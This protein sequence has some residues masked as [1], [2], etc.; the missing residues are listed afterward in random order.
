[1]G[2]HPRVLEG[3]TISWPRGGGEQ[4]WTTR[5]VRAG[6]R[7]EVEGCPVLGDP[8]PRG[9]GGLGRLEADSG[10]QGRRALRNVRIWIRRVHMD[11]APSNGDVPGQ[12]PGSLAAL[13]R[14]SLWGGDSEEGSRHSGTHTDQ[15]PKE[16]VSEILAAWLWTNYSIPLSLGFC[17]W[18]TDTVTSAFQKY[19]VV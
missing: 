19:W 18:K 17:I 12:D 6:M 9:N 11:N 5:M 3:R 14:S 8:W 15:S 13:G 1:M 4:W 7:R 16:Q 2:G 10:T